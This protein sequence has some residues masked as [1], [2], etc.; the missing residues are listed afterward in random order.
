MG[1]VLCIFVSH[2]FLSL[3][4]ICFYPSGNFW[5]L[6]QLIQ[7]LLCP[8]NRPL[9]RESDV[10][11]RDTESLA[12][13]WREKGCNRKRTLYTEPFRIWPKSVHTYGPEFWQCQLGAP[14]KKKGCNYC[15]RVCILLMSHLCSGVK[16]TIMTETGHLFPSNHNL[17]NLEQSAI[18][19]HL[20]NSFR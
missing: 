17:S 18:L 5:N 10:Q 3:I 1:M 15:K 8:F 14:S 19:V 2:S 13:P 16:A 11:V 9:E 12:I 4:H 6:R 7:Q 20:A